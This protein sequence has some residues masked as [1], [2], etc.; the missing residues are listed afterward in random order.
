MH[1]Y[2]ELSY[3]KEFAS[4]VMNE[5]PIGYI[6]KTVPGCGLTTVA[7]ENNED[8]IIAVPNT[9]LIDNKISQYPNGRTDN[10]VFGIHS[11]IEDL[12]LRLEEYLATASPIKIMVTYDSLWRLEELLPH[13]KLVIDESQEILKSSKLKASSKKSIYDT[14]VVTKLLEYTKAN[15]ERVSFISATPIPVEYMPEWISELP[16]IKM[17]WSNTIQVKPNLMQRTYVN[18]AL[19]QEIIAPIEANGKVKIGDLEFNKVIV[20]INSVSG[21]ADI[22]KKSKINKEDV[23]VIMGKTAMNDLKIGGIKRLTDYTNLTKYTFVTGSGFKG[24]DLYDDNALSIVISNTSKDYNMIDLTTDLQQAISRIRNKNNPNYGKFIYIYNQSPFELTEEELLNMIENN[25]QGVKAQIRSYEVNKEAN[26]KEGFRWD[27]LFEMYSTY[28]TNTDS[29]TL[30]DVLFNS[31]VHFIKEV[32]EKYRKGFALRGNFSNGLVV[33]EQIVIKQAS[34]K[35]VAEHY[36]NHN[37]FNGYENQLDYVNLIETTLK[38]Y[39]KVWIDQQ[40]AK[41]QIAAYNNEPKQ[42]LL[43][44]RKRFKTG[45]DY[46]TRY[47]KDTLQSVYNE[48]GVERR[49]KATDLSDYMSVE[50]VRTA[51]ERRIK[52]VNKNKTIK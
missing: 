37:N 44:I 19:R 43:A 51:S 31:D 2:K 9:E 49:A 39:G 27:E 25:K 13:C 28:D 18:K 11:E 30:N 48:Y 10:E 36:L 32:K 1:N 16:L 17:N 15:K 45:A 8:T 41:E 35:E 46:T 5:I 34:Y 24:I 12:D 20:Y 40:Y 26:N 14:D 29:F 38:L 4:E 50:N 52:I 21:I 23:R 3:D 7:L 6:D 42:V 33:E 22:V 47:V